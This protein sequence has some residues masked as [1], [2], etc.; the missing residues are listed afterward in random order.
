[1]PAIVSFCASEF[2]LHRRFTLFAL[3]LPFQMRF[4]QFAAH[5]L[6][7]RSV[8]VA[9]G[10]MGTPSSRRWPMIS[11]PRDLSPGESTCRTGFS[12]DWLCRL[13]PLSRSAPHHETVALDSYSS[14]TVTDHRCALRKPIQE[15]RTPV[16][17]PIQTK[18][19]APELLR[20]Q[21][22][23]ML[24]AQPVMTSLYPLPT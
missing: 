11:F 17:G 2:V 9:P 24:D 18:D 10:H 19:L 8:A 15:P 23:K 5:L 20:K 3:R 14:Q 4:H 1:M 7:S 13:S 16:L 6:F 21:P 22:S 12:P